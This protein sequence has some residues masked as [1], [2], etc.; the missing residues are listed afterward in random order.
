MAKI[1]TVLSALATLA[2]LAIALPTDDLTDSSNATLKRC[3]YNEDCPPGEWCTLTTWSGGPVCLANKIREDSLRTSL[4]R[5]NE[6]GDKLLRDKR[7][8]SEEDE[9]KKR[10]IYLP[11]KRGDGQSKPCKRSP[12]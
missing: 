6:I 8:L 3:K 9:T 4:K 5:D 1:L 2:I 12:S 11:G 7:S 10:G